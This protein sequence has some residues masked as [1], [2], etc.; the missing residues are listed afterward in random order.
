MAF[1]YAW[2][3]FL[4]TTVPFTLREPIISYVSISC[5]ENQAR[6][7]RQ[8]RSGLESTCREKKL[9]GSDLE[10]FFFSHST[11]H[12]VTIASSQ[13]LGAPPYT[14]IERVIVVML[15][16]PNQPLVRFHG[17]FP[18]WFTSSHLSCASNLALPLVIAFLW[19]T[20]FPAYATS[21]DIE[22]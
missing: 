16:R 1:F 20:C 4:T 19:P 3:S 17:E 18:H 2:F 14:F 9:F 11:I 22:K 5:S 10:F 21:P 7:V 6:Q 15:P 8:G 12:S 13:H